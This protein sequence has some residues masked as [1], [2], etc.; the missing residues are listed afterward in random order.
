MDFIHFEID[1]KMSD[2]NDFIN[3]S[4]EIADDISLYRKL[5]PLY[6]NPL[7][8]KHYKLPNKT[9]DPISAVTEDDELFFEDIDRQPNL[10]MPEGT[11]I[12]KFDDFDGFEKSIKK[13]QKS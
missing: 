13:F 6:P 4:E 8:H 2:N 3:D 12:F 10:Y 1:E 9:R 5:N 11:E 7:E